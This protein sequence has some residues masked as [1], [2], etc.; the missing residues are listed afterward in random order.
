[1]VE[2]REAGERVLVLL[3][4][5][6]QNAPAAE[7]EPLLPSS[8]RPLG[9]GW[10][11]A[12][13]VELRENALIR[14]WTV[15]CGVTGLEGERI[16][17]DGLSRADL[18]VLLRVVLADGRTARAVLRPDSPSFVVPSR[19]SSLAVVGDYLVL[20]FDH[21]LGG[22]DHLLFVLGLLFLIRGR[23]MLL[24][25]VTAFTLGHS[26]TLSLATLELVR[27]PSGPV[28]LAIAASIW[29]VAWELADKNSEHLSISPRER[30]PWAI[31]GVFGLLH[32]FGFAGALAEAGLPSGDIPLALFSF[33]IGIELG[34]IVFIACVLALQWALVKLLAAR[35]DPVRL[36]GRLELAASYLIGALATYWCLQ[37]GVRLLG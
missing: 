29:L 31:A 14:R 25:T 35:V 18:S 24:L 17:V 7:L 21:I 33:N 3:K 20:G 36:A 6:R 5:S 22:F 27:L 1:M 9:S 12:P 15:G 19:P 28:E 2:L 23:R 10:D 4:V 32:G 8:C 13:A 16:T 30:R 11:D 37:R 26:V 34:Q